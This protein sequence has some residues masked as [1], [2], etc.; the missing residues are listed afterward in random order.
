MKN[1]LK[2]ITHQELED[3]LTTGPVWFWHMK[4]NG[5]IKKCLATTNQDKMPAKVLPFNGNTIGCTTYYD[6]V[7]GQY[8]NCSRKLP[9]YIQV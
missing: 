9:V 7:V 2:R 6:I 5:D 1:I 8:R 3:L 4:V